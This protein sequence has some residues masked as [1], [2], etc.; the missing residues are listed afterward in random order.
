[1]SKESTVYKKEII[2]KENEKYFF[3]PITKNL[4]RAEFG[5][6]PVHRRGKLKE[7]FIY[8]L[9]Q[10]DRSYYYKAIV[11]HADS[12]QFESYSHKGIDPPRAWIYS[13]CR[14]H[15]TI[16]FRIYV[17]NNSNYFTIMNLITFSIYFDYDALFTAKAKN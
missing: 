11:H 6:C 10:E 14:E 13:W 15:K 9:Q 4:G 7:I 16:S 1:L 5:V 17:P 2:L 3:I 12:F 8:P